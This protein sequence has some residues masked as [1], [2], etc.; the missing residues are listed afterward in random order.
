MSKMSW[1]LSA[2]SYEETY[3]RSLPSTHGTCVCRQV[4]PGHIVEQHCGHRSWTLSNMVLR[5][6]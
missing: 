5:P 2:F 6:A 3:L 1:S 4:L